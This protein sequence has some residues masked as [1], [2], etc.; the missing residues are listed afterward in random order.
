MIAPPF[1]PPVPEGVTKAMNKFSPEQIFRHLKPAL[2]AVD[3]FFSSS[4][5]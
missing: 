1:A 4:R 3:G 5:F 2:K